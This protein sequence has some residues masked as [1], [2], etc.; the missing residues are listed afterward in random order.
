[1]FQR[2]SKKPPTLGV[3]RSRS[4]GTRFFLTP[5]PTRPRRSSDKPTDSS[6]CGNAISD[7][8]HLNA[9][10]GNRGGLGYPT[11]SRGAFSA[12]TCSFQSFII[13][14]CRFSM[15][16]VLLASHE[17]AKLV[18]VPQPTTTSRSSGLSL[19]RS[20]N[21]S[22]S[23]LA[24]YSPLPVSLSLSLSSHSPSCWPTRHGV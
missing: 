23:G 22:A 10:L 4:G 8:D 18:R 6:G 20:Y 5:P 17:L 11:S 19:Q 14:Y 24:S 13:L 2:E 12:L 7:A 9:L 21:S 15:G 16:F 1:M 3:V